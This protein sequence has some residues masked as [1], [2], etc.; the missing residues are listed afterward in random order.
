MAVS[1]EEV[2]T[3]LD[4]GLHAILGDLEK[5]EPSI[6]SAANNAL[7]ALGAPPEIGAAV[8]ALLSALQK[9]FAADQAAKAA[10]DENPPA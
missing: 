1:W 5:A 3:R 10:A 8:E 2:K 6:E 9:H 4:E 7:T